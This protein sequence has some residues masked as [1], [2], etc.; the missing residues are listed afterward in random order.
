M[1]AAGESSSRGPHIGADA[2]DP[3]VAINKHYIN[4]VAHAEGVNAGA[5]G[6]Q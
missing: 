1:S 3:P 5:G 2:N 6:N 4:R